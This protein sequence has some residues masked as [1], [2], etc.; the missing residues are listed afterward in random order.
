M[1]SEI[2][3]TKSGVSKAM[4][5]LK[6]AL[7]KERIPLGSL[8]VRELELLLEEQIDHY[9]LR[10]LHGFREL[11]DVLEIKNGGDITMLVASYT[12]II[13]GPRGF[14]EKFHLDFKSHVIKVSRGLLFRKQIFRQYESSEMTED[15]EVFRKWGK[16][17]YL[18]SGTESVLLLRRLP[19]RVYEE[20][21]LM[22]A[23]YEYGKVPN[24]DTYLISKV[25]ATPIPFSNFCKYFGK[26]APE[27]ARDLLWELASFYNL[28]AQDLQSKANIMR[29]KSLLK[30]RLSNSIC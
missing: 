18:C 16:S 3:K 22:E 2:G 15:Y 19:E 21:V 26:K 8:R 17:G 9:D 24:D 29:V 14:G 30:Q 12:S 10:E 6:Y 4:W 27:I 5:N 20:P 13:S 1:T 23:I 11:K 7:G 28:T 25:W